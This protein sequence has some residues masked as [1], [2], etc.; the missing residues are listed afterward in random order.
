MNGYW[1]DV[2]GINAAGMNQ[3]FSERAQQENE[4]RRGIK[5][6]RKKV[7]EAEWQ[8][9]VRALYPVM[10]SVLRAHGYPLPIRKLRDILDACP[11][12]WCHYKYMTERVSEKGRW[13]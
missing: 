10:R 5:L 4:L 8:G 11:S 1:S 6:T 3:G 2:R 12:F 9:T 13:R 7:E